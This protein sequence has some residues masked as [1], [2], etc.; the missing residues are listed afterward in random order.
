MQG[1]AELRVEKNGIEE[2]NLIG[3]VN[4]CGQGC[5]SGR[6]DRLNSESQVSLS[7]RVGT[8]CSREIEITRELGRSDTKEIR[9]I[10]PLFQNGQI[11]TALSLIDNCMMNSVGL[12]WP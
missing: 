11:V 7:G 12:N 5:P 1:L 9:K 4:L 10:V 6:V 8:G 2:L 3:E